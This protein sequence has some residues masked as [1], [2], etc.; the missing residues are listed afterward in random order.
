MVIIGNFIRQNNLKIIEKQENKILGSEEKLHRSNTLIIT[1]SEVAAKVQSTLDPVLVYQSLEKELRKLGFKYYLALLD[2]ED[3]DLIVQY[4]GVA[5]QALAAA[6]K[7]AGISIKDFRITRHNFP[8][9]E[10][11]IELQKPQY[12]PDVFAVAE[13][14][15]NDYPKRIKNGIARLIKMGLDEQILYFPL[16]ANEKTIGFIGIWGKSLEEEDIPAFSI[17]AGQVANA[18]RVS[19]LYQQ[20]QAANRA[21]TEFLSR[22]SHELRTPMNSILGF[23]QLLDISQKDPLTEG[24]RDRV[25]QI[26]DGGNHLL[27]LINEILDISRIEA[28]RLQ[29]YPEPVRVLDTLREMY[30]LAIPLAE[31]KDIQIE[32]QEPDGKLY[33]LA[34]QLRLKQVLLNLLSNAV[35]YNLRGGKVSIHTE[36]QP[37]G[38]LRISV[39]DTG[40][41]ISAKKLEQL[42]VPFERLEADTYEAEG[43]GLG[44]A[45]S[46]HLVELMG[47][48]IGVESEVGVGSTFWFELPL[49]NETKFSSN[50]KFRVES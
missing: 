6:E 16:I 17:F 4:V 32:L 13:I 24:Q 27:N 2:S 35:K 1:L 47:G 7:L 28:G 41:G 31:P 25:L 19:D 14:V 30:E 10:A 20:A 44:L 26:V 23:A 42:F 29:V 48:Q 36:V 49:S 15:L 21:K 11:L 39:T 37:L 18:I 5:S 40:K 50:I 46:K 12:F 43:T 45:L 33:L 22:M 38:Y 9:Y 3:Q 34:D 8:F